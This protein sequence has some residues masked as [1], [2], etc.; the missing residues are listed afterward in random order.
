VSQRPLPRIADK[1]ISKITIQYFSEFF[2]F[3]SK[4][5]YKI[6]VD[7]VSLQTINCTYMQQFYLIILLETKI[8]LQ[9]LVALT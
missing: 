4:Y 7:L 9:Y 1:D 8:Q 2:N 3:L 5:F 6:I